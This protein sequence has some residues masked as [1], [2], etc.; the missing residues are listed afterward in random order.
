MSLMINVKQF[1]RFITVD[2]VNLSSKGKLLSVVSCFIETFPFPP[3]LSLAKTTPESGT[4]SAAIA[5]EILPGRSGFSRESGAAKA[6]PTIKPT[7]AIIADPTRRTG[8]EG[9][10]IL[11][12]TILTGNPKRPSS[13]C[14]LRWSSWR[15]KSNLKNRIYNTS[16]PG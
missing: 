5:T 13:R 15:I 4:D 6:A 11:S 7:P 8:K 1:F 12:V 9:L 16:S 2:P 14:V 10:P 3:G